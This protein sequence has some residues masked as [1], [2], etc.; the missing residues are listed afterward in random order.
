MG[1]PVSS[2]GVLMYVRGHA[3]VYWD[4]HMY[5]CAGVL[6]CVCGTCTN[7]LNIKAPREGRGV[8]PEGC[9]FAYLGID[10]C[11]CKFLNHLWQMA[12]PCEMSVPESGH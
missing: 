11:V 9:R 7:A 8:H 1:L 5:V 6:V 2:M 4:V 10:L 12:A 3:C